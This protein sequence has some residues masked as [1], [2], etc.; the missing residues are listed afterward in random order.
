MSTAATPLAQIV[1]ARL[2]DG[3]FH[4]GEMLAEGAGVT[5]SAIWKAIEQLRELGLEIEAHTNK[6]YRLARSVEA[7]DAARIRRDLADAV[8]ERT[9]IQIVWEID[10]TN[11]TLLTRKR[12]SR[13][14]T[15]CCSLRIK[16][17][18]AVAVAVLG[19]RDSARVCVYRS[20]RVLIRCRAIYPR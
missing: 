12:Q 5:R 2:S 9:S 19:R 14:A 1:F 7:L 18:V 17:A 6:G 4:S 10:S 20:L 15:M 3:K 11:A 13:I 16:R 8:R